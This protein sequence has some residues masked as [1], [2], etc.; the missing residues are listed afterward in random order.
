MPCTPKNSNSKRA[1]LGLEEENGAV[2]EVEV[3][4]VLC[5][6]GDERAKVATNNAV[7]GR[8]LALIEL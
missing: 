4:E 6:V 1:L 8:A 2:A 3:Y 5:L 7:P